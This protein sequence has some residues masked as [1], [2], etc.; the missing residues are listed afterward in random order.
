M[1]DLVKLMDDEEIFT[2]Y[3]NTINLLNIKKNAMQ[4]EQR[5]KE[6]VLEVD[7]KT[8][9]LNARFEQLARKRTWQAI[10]SI[11]GLSIT[12]FSYFFRRR[13]APTLPPSLARSAA[14]RSSTVW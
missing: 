14:C 13:S 6:L 2:S 5:L 7:E 10:R 4:P 12:G 8:R 11:G 3:H 9:D 1:R